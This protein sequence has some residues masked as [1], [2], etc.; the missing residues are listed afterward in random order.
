MLRLDKIL[1]SA[2]LFYKNIYYVIKQLKSKKDFTMRLLLIMILSISLSAEESINEQIKSL[3]QAT[4]Q[5]RVEVM[6][7]IKEQ[8]I[9]MNQNE[10]MNTI[11]K[12]REKLHPHEKEKGIE[13]SEQ[14]DKDKHQ[15]EIKE[16]NRNSEADFKCQANHPREEFEH[17]KKEL[18]HI[19]EEFERSREN[20]RHKVPR[21]RMREIRE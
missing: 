7:H 21:N 4:P 17:P 15:E 8:L 9:E 1:T 19:R 18:E 6:N 13:E 14:H 3:E 10:R 20:H 5:E 12:L 16:G 2:T 11:A